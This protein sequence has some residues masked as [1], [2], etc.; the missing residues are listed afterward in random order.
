MHRYCL[1]ALL[2]LAGSGVAATSAVAD[3]RL[4]ARYT[5]SL[6]GLEL[7]R[8][9]LL[10]EIDDRSYTASGSARLTGVA[11]AVS[12]GKGTA[13]ARGA[14]SRGA[15]QPKAF[16]M[17]AE[18]E[19]KAE[20]IRLVMSNDTVTE[21]RVE[22]PVSNAPDRVPVTEKDKKNILDP[23]SAALIL[24]PGGEEPLSAKA[25]ERVLSIFDGRQRYDLQLSFERMENV[26]ADKGYSG[27]TVVC[28]IAYRPVAGHR[29]SR[30]GV[31]YMMNNKEMFVWL[32][33]IAGTRMLVPFRAAVNTALGVAQIEAESFVSEPMV[34]KGAKPTRAQ[35]P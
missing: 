27:P 10:L 2:A 15:L 9:A 31:K 19:R 8:A 35:V 14:I 24:V 4:E 16:A 29:P 13:G 17:E 28:R 25:C 12:A 3:G 18:T 32:A 30:S 11:Q 20:G 21:M 7:G 1:S 5:L 34:D 26:A 23:M 22:P 33:P 6:A